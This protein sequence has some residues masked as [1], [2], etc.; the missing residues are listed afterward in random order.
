MFFGDEC[1]Y[2]VVSAAAAANNDHV[3]GDGVAALL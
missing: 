3:R 2:R 1:E